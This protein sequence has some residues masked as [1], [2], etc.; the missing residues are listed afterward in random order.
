MNLHV[1]VAIVADMTEDF[2]MSHNG[3]V[4]SDEIVPELIDRSPV[5]PELS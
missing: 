3:C 1:H 2:V 5:S 4:D